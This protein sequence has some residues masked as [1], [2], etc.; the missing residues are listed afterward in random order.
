MET[1]VVVA[2]VELAAALRVLLLMSMTSFVASSLG[3]RGGLG[4]VIAT[5]KVVLVTSF[6]GS[7]IFDGADEVDSETNSRV[8]IT[9]NLGIQVF[10]PHLLSDFIHFFACE[11]HRKQNFST[12]FHYFG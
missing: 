12:I 1:G 9:K 3:G 8:K 4:L 5:G 6:F 11:K 7:S 10:F 2:L